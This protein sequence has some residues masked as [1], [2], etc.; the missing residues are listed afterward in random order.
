MGKWEICHTVSAMLADYIIFRIIGGERNSNG[1]G[2]HLFG[3]LNSN[4]WLSSSNK[5]YF[6]DAAFLELTFTKG[7]IQGSQILLDLFP[8]KSYKI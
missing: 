5:M 6:T 8:Q 2:I 3:N 4:C 1:S 7:I